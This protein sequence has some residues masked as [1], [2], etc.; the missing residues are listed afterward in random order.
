[1]NLTVGSQTIQVIDARVGFATK[2][3]IATTDGATYALTA[4]AGMFTTSSFGSS[5][6]PVT[7]LG[8]T[9]QLSTPGSTAYGIYT[10]VGVEGAIT[11]TLHLGLHLDGSW[12][13]DSIGSAGA[14]V[15]VGGVF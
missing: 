1:M 10:G 5:S 14:K 15:T 2:A 4:K 9:T 7:V 11:Q 12:R 8:Q 13:S 6:L 3:L